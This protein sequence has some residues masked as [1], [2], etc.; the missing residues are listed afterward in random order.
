MTCDSSLN[1]TKFHYEIHVYNSDSEKW[2]DTS[3]ALSY[4][5]QQPFNHTVVAAGNW[6]IRVVP[7]VA[8]QVASA[9][10]GAI[11]Y[12][13]EGTPSAVPPRAQNRET[14]TKASW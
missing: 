13:S 9:V 4:R 11:L 8:P 2:S 5:L 12:P 14:P 7:E 10:N 3:K 1:G 6:Y